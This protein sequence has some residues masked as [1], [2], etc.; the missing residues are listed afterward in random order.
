MGGSDPVPLSIRMDVWLETVQALL[1][2]LDVQHVSLMSHSAGTMYAFNTLYRMRDIL[3]PQRPYVAMIAPWV[4]NEHSH[5]LLWNLASKI[6]AGLFSSWNGIVRVINTHVAPSVGW[7]SGIFSSAAS[8]FRAESGA[9]D[10]SNL[11][12]GETYGVSEEVGE[13][14]EKLQRKWSLAESTTAG[15][16]EALLCLKKTTESDTGTG[17]GAYWGV[18]E[19]YEEYVR[20][21][22]KQEQ[23]RR[24][25][26][27]VTS[28]L[29]IDT[30]FAESDVMIG[31]EGQQYFEQCWEQDGVAD[32]MSFSS[33]VLPQTDH[34][35]ALA[36]LKKGALKQVFEHIA[37][38]S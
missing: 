6:P 37:G 30:F 35:S 11:T 4:H 23:E 18:C 38:Q 28:K 34:D 20:Q 7:S 13:C 17:S 3:D 12:P 22:A 2:T 9:G 8:M 14:I 29:R 19:D 24:S 15:N 5:Q 1:K 32:V 36:D 33:T 25:T 31:K 21:L 26:H 10:A 27:E 16:E